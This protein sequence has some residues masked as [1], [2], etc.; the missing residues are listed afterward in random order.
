MKSAAEA[1]QTLNS[2]TYYKNMMKYYGAAAE[3][4]PYDSEDL[5]FI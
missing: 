2:D 4:L 3:I 5:L 1:P